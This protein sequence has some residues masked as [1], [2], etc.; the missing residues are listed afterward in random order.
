MKHKIGPSFKKT[1]AKIYKKDKNGF[2][3][4]AKPNLCD[5]NTVVIYISRYLGRPVIALSRIDSYDGE[6][7]TFHYN[8]HEDNVYVQKTLPV[9]V[10][11][12]PRNRIIIKCLIYR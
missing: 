11:I 12:F 2:Y 10:F 5:P 6:N 1:K 8:R 4:Y 9:I 7:V 3:V